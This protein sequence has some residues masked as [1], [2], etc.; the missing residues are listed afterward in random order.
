MGQKC[1]GLFHFCESEAGHCY[2]TSQGKLWNQFVWCEQAEVHTVTEN[3][4]NKIHG[5]QIDF[6]YNQSIHSSHL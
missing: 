6:T 2:K 5:E 1:P 3:T 4:Q